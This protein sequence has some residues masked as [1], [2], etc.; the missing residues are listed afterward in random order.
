[1][2]EG[3]ATLQDFL[4][5]TV[6]NWFS[7]VLNGYKSLNFTPLMISET[8]STWGG[9]TKDLSDTYAAGF[10]WLDKLGLS[11]LNGLIVVAR[12]AIFGGNYALLDHKMMPLPV[13]VFYIDWDIF[14][15]SGCLCCTKN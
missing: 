3:D 4:N 2:Y 12:Q 5:A 6:L 8:S 14:R 11:A 10:V 9:G 15:I 13:S 1:M 7:N